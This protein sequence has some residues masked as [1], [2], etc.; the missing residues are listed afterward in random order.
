MCQQESGDFE[1]NG[2]GVVRLVAIDDGELVGL[3][4]WFY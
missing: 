3:S 2:L 1:G 4:Q